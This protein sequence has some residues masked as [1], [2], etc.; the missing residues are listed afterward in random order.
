MSL[1]NDRKND[2]RIKLS[3]FA[4]AVMA[5]WH[6]IKIELTSLQFPFGQPNRHCRNCLRINRVPANPLAIGP[7][8]QTTFFTERRQRQIDGCIWH[9]WRCGTAPILR[10]IRMSREN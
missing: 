1:P 9:A 8:P 10:R 6:V 4:L 7:H 2:P 3:C 5:W